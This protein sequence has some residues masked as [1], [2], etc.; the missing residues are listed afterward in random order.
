MIEQRLENGKVADVLIAHRSFERLHF[1]RN[2]P[3]AAMHVNDLLRE[4]PI[5]RVDL[6]LRFEIEQAKV[7]R[8]LRFFLY[9]L[10]VMQTF[11]AIAAFQSLFRVENVADEFM[12]LDRKSVV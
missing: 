2:K 10:N 7:E 1:L 9:L 4:L 11:E 12:I 6:G 3:Q 5:D 8:L